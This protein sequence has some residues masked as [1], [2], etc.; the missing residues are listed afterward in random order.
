MLPMATALSLIPNALIQCD[1]DTSPCPR[2]IESGRAC[3]L[4]I[5]NT[6][7]VPLCDVGAYARQSGAACALFTGL[8]VLRALSK[9]LKF[10]RP[11]C[12]KKAKLPEES[13]WECFL[14]Q[15]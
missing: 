7:K 1:F 6:T 10:L 13:T 2:F 12:C 3:H 15:S 14:Q 5:T 4:L 11:P 8:L 9:A